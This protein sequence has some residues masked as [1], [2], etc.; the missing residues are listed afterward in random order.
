MTWLIGD[1]ANYLAY[2]RI[3]YEFLD[4]TDVLNHRDNSILGKYVEP[5]SDSA[6]MQGIIGGGSEGI[7]Y[8]VSKER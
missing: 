2:G 5:I 1:R 3:W 6:G 4:P 7:D 8:S